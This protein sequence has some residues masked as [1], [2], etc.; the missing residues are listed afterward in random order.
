M[1]F[2][3]FAKLYA[4]LE[5]TTKK[6]EKRDIL[7][8]FY[9][10]SENLYMS[11]VLSTGSVGDKELGVA[12]E[13]IKRAIARVTGASSKELLDAFKQTGDLGMTVE[14]LMQKRKQSTLSTRALTAEKVYEN[15]GKLPELT[16]SGSQDKKISLI[17]ELLSSSTPQ[18]AKYIV[19]TCLGQMRVGV[20]HGIVRDAIAK[21]FDRQPSAVEHMFNLVGDYGHVAEKA[22]SGKMKAEIELFR[23]VRVMLAD[24]GGIINEALSIFRSPTLEWK[25]DGFRV[26][27]HKQGEKIKIFSRRMEDVTK[28]FPDIVKLAKVLKANSCIVD[29]EAIAYDF[30]NNVIL[31]FQHLSRRIQRK[32][33]IDKMIRDI[34]VQVNLFDIIYLNGKNIMNEKLQDRWNMLEKIVV[35]NRQDI[36]LARHI[37]KKSVLEAKQFYDDALR[38]GQEGVIVKNPDAHYQ[39]GKRVGYWLKVKPI[40]EP[41][42]LVIIGAEWGEGKRSKWLSSVILGAKKGNRIVGTG[43]MASGFT[44]EQLEELTKTLRPLITGEDGKIVKVTPKIV[45]EIGYEE[46]QASP[47]Y[48]SGYALRFPRLLRIRTDEK[49]VDDIDAVETITKLYK[50][51]RGRK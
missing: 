21:A 31:P 45:I 33:D 36:K 26:Q 41:L 10:K 35:K 43:R 13:L 23:P 27:I 44:E 47:K 12:S 46:I 28:Q 3:E 37:E 30:K 9:S 40:L 19:R 24:R 50:K 1:K 39:P 8:K 38:A 20:A 17:S 49:T 2:S 29:G 32:Y 22:K 42:D 14:R 7:A 15:L 34:P 16:G 25:Y 4:E 5:G 18:E 6:L 48:E 11:V 51:Q